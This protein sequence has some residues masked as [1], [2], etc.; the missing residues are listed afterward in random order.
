[1]KVFNTLSATKEDFVPHGGTVKMY[2][3]GPTPYEAAHIGHAMSYIVFDVIR[4]Y[5]EY[6]GYQVR[7]AQNFTDIDDKIIDRAAQRSISPMELAQEYIAAF[8]A[9]MEALN[10]QRAH[11]YP[12]VT[13]EI[14]P[15]IRLIE[16]LVSQSHAY[17]VD[18]DVYFRVGSYP[19]YGQ[20]A[21]RSLEEL[22]AGARVE[23]DARKEHPLDFALWK[24]AKPGE[25]AWDSP[26]GRGR[27]GWHIECS[28]M[29]LTYLGEQIDIHGGG[30]DLIFPH[31]ENERG[32]TESF[33]GQKP[34]VKYW[35]HNGLLRLGEE[36]MSKS[37]GNL[38]TIKEA[39]QRF[40][41]DALRLFV[42]F[43][44]YRSPLTYSDEAL[45]AAERGAERLRGALRPAPP[46]EE[47]P[48]LREAAAQA[49]HSFRQAM[50][51]DFNTPAA[52]ASL[53]DLARDINRA[54]EQS[55]DG[56][57]LDGAQA[58]LREL[59]GVMGLTL[60]EPQED[61]A[62]KPF[63][64]LLLEIRGE[65]RA[66]KQ[67]ALADRIRQGLASLG[68]A[69]EDRPDGTAWRLAR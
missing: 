18:G 9:E 47:A 39:L 41:A 69:V 29:A 55:A 2:V 62:A 35:L 46:G 11:Y 40:S 61:L 15:I 65:L 58:T 44:H 13:Q 10:V 20:L 64:E 31:H 30:Q 1:M 66:A 50:E 45:E 57:A 32:Q 42:L 67:W 23:I 22:R 19:D 33:T 53:F 48:F 17:P 63:L 6:A 43:S 60:K 5:L 36:K 7:H 27:P 56:A 14:G 12:R 59:A 24:A 37:L 28:A 8:F 51:D 4:R 38:I 52:L 34:F 3:C 25:P 16:G 54:R 68:I 49:Q 26:W 21:H